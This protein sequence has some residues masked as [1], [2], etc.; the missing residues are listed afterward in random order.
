MTNSGM[1]DGDVHHGA[2]HRTNDAGTAMA[3]DTNAI[4]VV[5]IGFRGPGD[6]TNVEEFYKLLA[7]GRQTWSEIPKDRWNLQ[8]HYHKDNMRNGAVSL[9][10]SGVKYAVT[11][12]NSRTWEERT[13]SSIIWRLSMR[14]SSI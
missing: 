1:L 4:A 13:S 10:V 12:R 9:A 3:E 11:N 8:A 5:G 7:Q 6:A 2:R 14:P